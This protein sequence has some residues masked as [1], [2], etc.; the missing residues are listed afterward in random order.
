[1]ADREQHAPGTAIGRQP[2]QGGETWTVILTREPSNSAE[3]QWGVWADPLE[4]SDWAPFD[5]AG[6]VGLALT[7]KAGGE[8]G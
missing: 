1:M 6:V 3:A 5:V 7:H 2:R 8:R 4:E